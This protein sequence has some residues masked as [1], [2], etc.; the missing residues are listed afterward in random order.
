MLNRLRHFRRAKDGIAATEFALILPVMIML[1]FGIEELSLAFLCKA[2][3]V[4][5]ASTNAD[6]VAQ[7]S[8]ATAADITNI[9]NAAADLLYPYSAAPAK[10]AITSLV[11]DPI[12]ASLTQGRV[13]WSCAHGGGTARGLNAM[14]ALPPGLMT[15]GGS[16]IMSEISYGY[17]SAT[18]QVITGPVNMTNTFYARPRRSA[19]V[20]RPATCP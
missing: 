18:T 7:E 13:D 20:T 9:W 8:Q 17:T 4:A 3:V 10:M 15:V 6:L 2:D 5:V 16:V 12:S 11:Y 19:L 1:F 14:V